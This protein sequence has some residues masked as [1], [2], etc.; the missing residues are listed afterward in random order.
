MDG[1]E[2]YEDTY[3]DPRYALHE[4][5]GA[6]DPDDIDECVYHPNCIG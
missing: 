1:T 3:I 5:D 2:Y 6:Y 4:F